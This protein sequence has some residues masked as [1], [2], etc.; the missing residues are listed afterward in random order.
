MPVSNPNYHMNVSAISSVKNMTEE[1]TES[2]AV[3]KAEAAK[4]D[5][6]AIRKLAQQ[7]AVNHTEGSQQPANLV[8]SIKGK[9]NTKA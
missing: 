2:S 6:Q 9:L 4:G 1:A 3:T 7:Q 8:D 5:R